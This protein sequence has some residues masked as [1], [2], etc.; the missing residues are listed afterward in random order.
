MEETNKPIPACCAHTG[1]SR[2]P[3]Q[4]GPY[5]G[6]DQRLPTS[7]RS[8]DMREPR[9]TPHGTQR[10]FGME[11][12]IRAPRGIALAVALAAPFW[13]VLLLWLVL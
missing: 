1:V 5:S 4:T 8:V 3:V 9:E 11:S 7:A 2:N 12:W 10:A 13:L 6:I